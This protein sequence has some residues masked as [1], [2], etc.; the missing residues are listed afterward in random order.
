MSKKREHKKKIFDDAP[1]L[2]PIIPLARR[3]SKLRKEVKIEGQDLLVCHLTEMRKHRDE[4][5]ELYK[6]QKKHVKKEFAKEAFTLK[7]KPEGFISIGEISQVHCEIRRKG[8]NIPLSDKITE[9]LDSKDIP[10][11]RHVKIPARWVINEEAE[12]STLEIV[13]KLLANHPNKKVRE[14]IKRQPKETI[15][16]VSDSTIDVM[17]QKCTQIEIDEFLEE[18][19]FYAPCSRPMLYNQ[20]IYDG[21]GRVTDKAHEIAK[22][23]LEE[24][25]IAAKK[26]KKYG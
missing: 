17:A 21:N 13:A 14:L 11:D 8:S 9:W 23:Y 25:T 12:E 1:E 15:N 6:T 5:L 22:D 26:A 4:F 16:A 18:L 7:K 2:P 20:R 3:R 19:A 24:F 10:Y